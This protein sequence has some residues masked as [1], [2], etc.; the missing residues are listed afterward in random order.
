MTA[1]KLGAVRHVPIEIA[2]QGL[3]VRVARREAQAGLQALDGD[4]AVLARRFVDPAVQRR[5][6]QR[7]QHPQQPHG[8]ALRQRDG[9]AAVA[10]AVEHGLHVVAHGPEVARRDVE[11][12]V[13]PLCL[14][15][16]AQPDHL[17]QVVHVEQLVAVVAPSEQREA[18]AVGGPLVEQ[19]EG[20]QALGA[21]EAL[22][23]QHRHAQAAQPVL[24]AR[25]FGLDLGF[26]VGPH[27]PHRVGLHEGVVVGD[28]VDRRRRNEHHARHTALPGGIEHQLRAADVGGADLGFRRQRQRRGAV[29]DGLHALQGPHHGAG[30]AHV[31]QHRVDA[32]ALG[33]IEGRDVQRTHAHAA[34]QQEADE[35]DAQ[36]PRAARHQAVLQPRGHLGV[37]RHRPFPP[38]GLAPR[39]QQASPQGWALPASM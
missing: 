18:V 16:Q 1:L 31:A 32:I 28:A 25:A 8:G 6:V 14:A 2:L 3:P 9:A 21:D 13:D 19:F 4:L 24:D 34:R 23:S 27:A 36:E 22:R 37:V 10:G 35:V 39:A 7:L 30:V 11:G 26:A 12:V 15:R 20:A 5:Q 38:D 17:A 29:H 33:V